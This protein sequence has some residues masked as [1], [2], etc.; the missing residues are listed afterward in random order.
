MPTEAE[1]PGGSQFDPLRN[2]AAAEAASRDIDKFMN[3]Y[4]YPPEPLACVISRYLWGGNGCPPFLR[5]VCQSRTRFLGYRDRSPRGPGWSVAKPA[6]V[7]SATWLSCRQLVAGD[8][9]FGGLVGPLRRARD[10]YQRGA[11]PRPACPPRSAPLPRA[12]AIIAATRRG[13]LL[14][15]LPQDLSVRH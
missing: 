6:T 3:K 8:C 13:L 14:V 4:P 5:R 12:A 2:A 7:G 9:H 15:K 10:Q 1:Q 11:R